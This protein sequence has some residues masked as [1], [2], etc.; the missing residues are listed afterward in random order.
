MTS[1]VCISPKTKVRWAP[2][3]PDTRGTKGIFKPNLLIKG[4]P[5]GN[6]QLHL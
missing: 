1:Y 5:A 6:G 3:Q 4:F 2:L